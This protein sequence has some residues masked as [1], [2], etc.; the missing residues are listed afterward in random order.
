VNWPF[1]ALTALVCVFASPGQAQTGRER[2]RAPTSLLGQLG[3]PAAERLLASDDSGER[4][5]GLARLSALGSPR[6]VELLARA[7]DPG[8]AARGAE[9]HLAAVRALAPHVKQPIARDALVRALSSPA[10]DADDEALSEWVQSAAALALA[11]SQEPA[12][13]SALGRALRKPGRVAELAA[14]ALVAYPPLDLAPILHVPGAPTRELG[15]ALGA[16]GD[17]RAEAYLREIVRR[18]APEARAAAALALLRLGSEEVVPLARH[19][20]RSE[21]QPALLS[22]AAQILAERAP[23][24]AGPALATLAETAATRPAS[25]RGA[26]LTDGRVPAPAWLDFAT[27]GA[28]GPAVLELFARGSAW[29][30]PRLERALQA[31]ES[32]GLALYALSRTPGDYALSRL[33]RALGEPKLAPRALRALALRAAR[34]GQRSHALEERLPGAVGSRWP[35]ERAA[36]A[37]ARALLEPS[38]LEEGLRSKDVHVV[39]AVARLASSGVAARTAVARLVA[40]RD[41]SLRAALARGLADPE[42]AAL[43]PTPRLLE[44]SH[45]AGPGSLVA[46]SVLAARLDA[47]LLPLVREFLASGDPWLRAHTLLGLGVAKAPEALG[48]LEAAYRF[49]PDSAVRHAAVVALSRRAEPVKARPLSLAA[50][51]DS[52]VEVREAARRALSGQALA[53]GV[54]GPETAWLELVANPGLRP[55]ELPA[56]QLRF[57][58]GLALPVV[59]DADGVVA[60][61]GVDPAAL[62][63]R[64]A[65]SGGRVNVPGARP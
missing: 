36:A 50:E 42:A 52:A 53:L 37:F 17:H 63:V 13:L 62:Q 40:E 49:E 5:R 6:A 27:A 15:D 34:L 64:L 39:R 45:E 23:S 8:G 30:A 18:A 57:G 2:P 22:A 12:A 24:E 48:L 51:L 60:L 14:Q 16:L 31:P 26:L 4:L 28:Q 47:D 33:E 10:V 44:L 56:A 65:L 35:A 43:L 20:L 46:A 1:F 38:A 32:A 54:S 25:L 29:A 61:A 41:A 59:A 19:W 55:D 9:E 3:A 58:A 11:R 21:R 7:L